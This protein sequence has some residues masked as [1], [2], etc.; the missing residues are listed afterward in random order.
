M[1]RRYLWAFG[2][3]LA[4]GALAGCGDDDDAAGPTP[5]DGAAGRSGAGAAGSPADRG[6][7]GGVSETGGRGGQGGGASGSGGGGGTGA[8]PETLVSF[9][10]ARGEFIEGLAV[11]GGKAYV[12]V[13]PAGVVFE[14][15][16]AAKSAR[17]FGRTPPVPPD[18]GALLGL[19]VDDDGTLYA[20]VTSQDPA[21]LTS[22]VYRFAPG[23]GAAEL[24]ASDPAMRFPNDVRVEA[25]RLLV[26][27]SLGGRIYAIDKATGRA[28]VWLESPLLAPDPSVCD[29]DTAFHLGANGIA[30][31]GDAYY[32]S[33]T[34]KG[35]VVRVPAVGP[36]DDAG[37]PAPL[38]DTDCERLA[39]ADGIAAAPDGSLWLAVNFKN[40]LVHLR[41]DGTFDTV[42]RGAPLSSPAAL[43]LDGGRLL[44]TAAAFEKSADPADA[45]PAL[46]SFGL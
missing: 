45:R 30:R 22:G 29:V 31:Q 40:A 16:L 17:E 21:V 15:D 4:L 2:G 20:G 37:A 3:A 10:A 6:G 1:R 14:V 25:S 27:D 46:L 5:T 24:F 44:I 43:A 9:D 39:G 11:R 28:S 26:T 18:R 35:M 12:G 38:L 32:V 36:L 8:T 41:P 33:N 19:G 23:G 34:D 13:L 7:Q 42:A